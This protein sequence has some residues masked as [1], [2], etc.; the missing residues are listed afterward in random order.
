MILSI[1]YNTKEGD[2][3]MR[4]LVLEKKVANTF[5]LAR[6]S[7][8]FKDVSRYYITYNDDFHFFVNFN[9]RISRI[10]Y[11]L[12]LTSKLDEVEH[13][14][15]CGIHTSMSSIRK[16]IPL[17]SVS[18]HELVI[19]NLSDFLH[20]HEVLSKDSLKSIIKAKRN[21]FRNLVHSRIKVLGFK[22]KYNTWELV[23]GEYEIVLYLGKS[24]F[25]DEYDFYCWVYDK[26]ADLKQPLYAY[27]N[28]RLVSK[29][30]KQFFF[31]WILDEQLFIDSLDDFISDIVAPLLMGDIEKLVFYKPRK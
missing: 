25:S 4:K 30:T 31:D 24:R 1:C 9:Y 29:K 19:K 16:S 15:K 12:L 26:N 5:N 20:E 27:V 22:R 13:F 8:K 11:G 10:E 18:N 23:Q 21:R 2:G 28:E 7:R 17:S 3:Y 14:A 6:V